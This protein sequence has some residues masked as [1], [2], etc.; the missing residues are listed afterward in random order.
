MSSLITVC[1]TTTLYRWIEAD[2]VPEC[3][4]ILPSHPT[5]APWSL[6]CVFGGFNISEVLTVRWLHQGGTVFE[7]EAKT[8]ST[9]GVF[10]HRVSRVTVD[11][12]GLV[13]FMDEFKASEDEV[14][15][16]C[17]VKLIT[18]ETLK[19]AVNQNFCE[20]RIWLGNLSSVFCLLLCL[21]Y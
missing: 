5:A 1:P 12:S 2:V 18:G 11:D 14:V 3:E 19:N 6:S 8:N 21:L 20:H 13:V 4:R 10:N 17:N 16:E 7:Y 15:W 9:T